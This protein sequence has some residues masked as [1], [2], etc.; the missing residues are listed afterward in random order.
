M[1]QTTFCMFMET[2]RKLTL[3]QE[4]HGRAVIKS[5][6]EIQVPRNQLF[7]DAIYILTELSLSSTTWVDKA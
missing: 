1:E 4:E 7:P 5:N 3:T 2:R 6:V